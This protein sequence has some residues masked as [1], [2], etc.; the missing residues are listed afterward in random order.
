MDDDM[1]AD[2]WAVDDDYSW[3]DIT[4]DKT[5]LGGLEDE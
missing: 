4:T 2:A 1:F 3:D 5:D